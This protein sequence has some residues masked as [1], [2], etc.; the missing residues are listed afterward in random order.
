MAL[1]IPVLT[2]A[3]CLLSPDNGNSRYVEPIFYALPPLMVLL[4]LP[5]GARD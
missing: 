3:I 2:V 5:G 4:T 1:L